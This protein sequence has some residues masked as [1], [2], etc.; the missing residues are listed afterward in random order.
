[1]AGK[2]LGMNSLSTTCRQGLIRCPE[3]WMGCVGPDPR[4]SWARVA[5]P[6]VL[7]TA[8]GLSEFAYG[9][10]VFPTSPRLGFEIIPAH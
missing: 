1:M 8:Q 9:N 10:E 3:T 4:P 5:N 6:T 7:Q 2:A